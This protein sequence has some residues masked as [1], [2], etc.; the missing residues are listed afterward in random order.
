[1]ELEV[2]IKGLALDP[3]LRA[4]VERRVRGALARFGDRVHHA[5]VF[6]M[7][8]GGRRSDADVRC[9]I[10]TDVRPFGRVVV[11]DT[12]DTAFQAIAGA[13]EKV[14]RVVSRRLGRLRSRK[15]ATA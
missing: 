4:V 2:D 5:D 12:H 15:L 3:E 7:E 8:L 11:Q 14:T 9:R 10:V 1:M 13:A 6:F